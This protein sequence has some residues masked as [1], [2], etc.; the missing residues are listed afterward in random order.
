M[1]YVIIESGDIIMNEKKKFNIINYLWVI[2]LVIGIILGIS[3][4]KKLNEANDMYVP[5]MSSID[6]FDAETR[7]STA[8]FTGTALCIFGFGIGIIGTII[9]YTLP[10]TGKFAKNHISTVNEMIATN[11]AKATE[12]QTTKTEKLKECKYCGSLAK[13]DATECESCG[14]KSFIKHKH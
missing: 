9:C 10:R 12:E 4:I 5:P 3:G 2:P 1:I 8:Q 6:W 13:L 7:K 11:I 14:G